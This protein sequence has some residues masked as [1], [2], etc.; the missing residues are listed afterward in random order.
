TAVAVRNGKAEEAVLKALQD[1]LP[2]TRQAAAEAL[3]R[4]GGK[5]MLPKV[6]PLLHDADPLVRLRVAL[7][8]VESKDQA[9]VP[10]LIKLL[11]D[12]PLDRAW[13]AEEVL[14]LVAGDKAPAVTL[15]QDKVSRQ[16]C[17][18]EWVKWWKANADKVDLAKLDV[19]SRTLGYT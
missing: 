19:S 5:A 4:A 7:A 2:G 1:K 9:G 8:Y 13:E 10:V 6:Q 16:K 12:L 17:R 14:F 18:D 3:V 15:G 11:A